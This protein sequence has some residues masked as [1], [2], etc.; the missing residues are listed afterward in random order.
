MTMVKPQPWSPP[1]IKTRN[2]SSNEPGTSFSLPRPCTLLSPLPPLPP[3]PPQILL[4]ATPYGPSSEQSTLAR[5]RPVPGRARRA[6]RGASRNLRLHDDHSRARCLLAIPAPSTAASS[7][8]LSPSSATAVVCR[9]GR[10]SGTLHARARRAESFPAVDLSRP[11]A[12]S[13]PEGV[14]IPGVAACFSG[15]QR[16]G[17][18]RRLRRPSAM[19]MEPELAATRSWPSLLRPSPSPVR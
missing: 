14:L 13:L 2:G 1:C 15:V 17:A 18:Q 7:T 9:H 6:R 10:D 12:L 4:H 5:A 8:R 16:P 3:F 11:L 19:A